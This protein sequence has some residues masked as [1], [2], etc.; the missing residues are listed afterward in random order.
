ME[1]FEVACTS[2]G[3]VVD[4]GRYQPLCPCGGMT[5]VTY[6]TEDA[7]LYETDNPYHR[8]A[9][10]LPVL[11]PAL[12]PADA[13]PTPTVHA[14]ALGGRVG[15]SRLYLK[16][17]TVL[18]TGTTKDRMAAVAL[19]YLVEAGVE[20]FCTSSTGN[21]STAFAHRIGAVPGIRM[22]LFTASD[23]ADRLDLPDDEAV[24]NH[25]LDGA[26]F[27]EAFEAAREYAAVHGLVS[28]RGFFNPGRRE[29]LKLSF[30]EACDQVPGPIDWYV[31]AVSSAM[32]VVG[33]HGG[34][35]QLRAM[36]RIDRTP[37]LLC[38]QQESCSPMVDAWRAGSAV[39]RPQDV[40]ERPVGIAQAILRG[41]PSG[42]YPHVRARVVES[43][44][45]FD[46]VSE[47][48][49]RSAR[50]LVNELEGIDPC[51]AASA[52]V[53]GAA[54]AAARGIIDPDATVVVNLTG[55]DRPVPVGRTSPVRRLV[56]TPTGWGEP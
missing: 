31:Q 34:A 12:L 4:R 21:S 33:V 28:E 37:R 43:G 17:E 53:A 39:I 51:F 19:A 42:A 9:D 18:P 32:G 13:R 26:T 11:D 52:A 3:S 47:A 49:I 7:R 55:S 23:F 6:R 44:G 2:C 40:V 50:R 48:E 56:P 41:D 29:G 54:K 20:A 16:N 30:L 22:I 45:D 36:G 14:T 5:D 35:R 8:F 46:A 38:V 27:V 1:R 24:V 15:L 10:L 25:V